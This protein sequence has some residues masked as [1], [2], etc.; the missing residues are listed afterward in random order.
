M[1]SSWFT[2]FYH[3]RSQ[4]LVCPLV[5]WAYHYNAL[6]RDLLAYDMLLYALHMYVGLCFLY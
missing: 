5:S 1:F 3:F 4:S 2:G 6:E